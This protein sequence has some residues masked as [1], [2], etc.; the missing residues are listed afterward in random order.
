MAQPGDAPASGPAAGRAGD[1]HRRAR[2]PGRRRRAR[3]RAQPGGQ[4]RE[5]RAHRPVALARAAAGAA[6]GRGPAGRG[7]TATPPV[8]DWA[9][10]LDVPPGAAPADAAPAAAPACRRP[11]AGAL[12]HRHRAADPRPL[13]GL[14]PAHPEAAPLGPDRRRCRAVRSAGQIIHAVLEEFVRRLAGAAAGGPAR[15]TAAARASAV[16]PAGA[17]ARRSGRCGGRASSGSRPGSPRSSCGGA[18]SWSGS[19]ARSRARSRSTHR[20][21]PFTLRARADRIEVGRD[22]RI[23]DRRLQDRPDA[24]A[25]ATSPAACRRSCRSRR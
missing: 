14:C 13:R 2:L 7:G 11:A 25:A 5:R 9:R 24:P 16:R 6:H 21:A 20:A 4:G 12:G 1:R 17:H 18:P 3:G 19:P 22:G 10:R 23:G 8:A 15:R